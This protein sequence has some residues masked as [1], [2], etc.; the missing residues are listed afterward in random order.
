MRVLAA[1]SRLVEGI[2]AGLAARGYPDLRPAHGFAFARIDAGDA[3]VL[4]V[5]AH[6]GVTKQAASQLVEQ[7]VQGGYLRRTPDA[8]D[9]RRKVLALTARG[10][11]VTRAAEEAALQTVG[12]W[13]PELGA[14]GLRELHDLLAR[15]DLAGPLR[16]AW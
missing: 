14:A 2:Q 16:P 11:A 5:A 4:D 12:Q 15:L 7:L 3:T 8:A 13:R 10:R 9:A 1:A 6:L